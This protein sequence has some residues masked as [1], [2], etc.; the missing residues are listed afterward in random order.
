[1][2]PIISGCFCSAGIF[3]LREAIKIVA[4]QY[5]QNSIITSPIIYEDLRFGNERILKSIKRKN[6]TIRKIW[7]GG[8]PFRP[9]N[10]KLRVPDPC[11]LIL[12]SAWG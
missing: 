7:A 6:Q 3:Q 8:P 2:I 4:V 1:M 5:Q 9:Q 11:C 10:V 12:R